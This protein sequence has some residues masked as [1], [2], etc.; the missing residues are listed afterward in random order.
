MKTFFLFIIFL[1]LLS[2]C[3]MKRDP[4]VL[5]PL[6]EDAVKNHTTEEAGRVSIDNFK[7]TGSEDGE[8]AIEGT[9]ATVTATAFTCDF[10]LEEDTYWNCGANGTFNTDEL[11]SKGLDGLSC[12]RKVVNG[13]SDQS[14]TK[15]VPKGTILHAS[16]EI[17]FVDFD[18]RIRP[19][20][21]IIKIKFLSGK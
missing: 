7:V 4:A 9:W 18:K 2:G 20:R 13:L 11:N 8:K 5:Q 3:D 21:T 14:G 1:L 16:G 15:I 6:L 17:L 12:F 19:S 10:R